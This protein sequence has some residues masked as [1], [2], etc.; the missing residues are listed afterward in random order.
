MSEPSTALS[1]NDS[2]DRFPE[3]PATGATIAGLTAG[4]SALPKVHAAG[5]DTI[6]VGLVGC[7]SR[8]TGAANQAMSAGKDVRL[9]AMA[10]VFRDFLEKSRARLKRAGGENFA[11]DDDHCFVGFD[12]YRRLIDC[13]VD[14]VLLATPPHFRPA[15]LKAAIEAGKHVFAE[16]PVAV[17]APGVRSVM[18]TCDAAQRKKLSVVC[19]LM[20]RYSHGMRETMK[21]IHDGVIGNIVA[22]QANYN[23]GGLWLRPRQEEWS[24]MEWQMRNWYYFTWLSGDHIVE[25][26]VHGLDLMAWAM[27]DEHPVSCAGTGGRQARTGP[28]YG[29]I[30]DHHCVCYE[31]ANGVRCYSYCR[32][33]DGTTQD[34]SHYVFGSQGTA[35]LTKRSTTAGEVW[36]YSRAF[37]GTKDNMYQQ[38][39]DALFAGI[40]SGRPINNGP[41][42]AKSTLM[43]IMGR[44]ATYTGRRITWDEAWNSQE[45]LT[46][47]AYRFGPMPVPPVAVPGETQFR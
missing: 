31:Y 43:S 9:V 37:R 45:D 14:V 18:A 27:K 5:S 40:R 12:A 7:G 3:R 20:L 32:Q 26:H 11:V 25:Q 22:L 21:R 36:R 15:H 41:Y 42:T 1:P 30:F 2:R 34:T 17:D 8:G 35:D 39:H 23:I 46:P 47:A 13:G 33:Q 24:D 29:H 28:E 4:F 10:D 19:G 16:K 6:R 38:E 44:M